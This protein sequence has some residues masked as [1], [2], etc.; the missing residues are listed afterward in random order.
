MTSPNGD[1][2]AGSFSVGAFASWRAQTEGDAKASLKGVPLNAWS[3]A[4]TQLHGE[5]IS[6][7][8]FGGE[9]SRL[10]NRID[11]I[12]IG[13]ERV[14]RYTYAESDV[15]TKHP[16]AYKID[17]AVFS[18][19]TSGKPGGTSG[20]GGEGGFGGGF[21]FYTFAGS[22][23]EDLTTN[24]AITIGGGT[25]AGNDG[26]AGASLFGAYLSSDGAT[27][28]NYGTGSRTYK[29][30][31]GDGRSNNAGGSAGSDG[32]FHP[33][34]SVGSNSV[35][36]N[37][38][39]VDYGQVGNGS[40]GGGGGN[41]ASGLFWGGYRGG[42]GGWPGGAGG[43]GGS[44]S[45]F[46]GAGAG[47][48]GAGGMVVVTVYVEDTLGV[49]PSTP[50]NLVASGITSS[51]AHVTWDA[52]TD[53]VM[54]K[55]YALYL[56]GNRYGVV[57]APEHDFVGLAASTSYTVRVQAVDIGDNPSEMSAVLNFTTTS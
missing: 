34:G 4:Q 47:G 14:F 56:N 33:G 16:A 42:H 50:S 27:R 53:D 38:F 48:N 44:G 22:E 51:S 13:T 52:S 49:P 9:V 55:H 1:S 29:M 6:A 17:V 25:D 7:P 12:L 31:G 10:D 18:G 37:G 20:G 19:A 41:Y 28:T 30:R 46:A 45:A 24:V 11:E 32:P 57:S 5:F 36:G 15:W 40:C 26:A 21:N 8:L 23:L 35:G 3:G 43:G 39:S 2:P 54:V